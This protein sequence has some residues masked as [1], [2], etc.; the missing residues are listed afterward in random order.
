MTEHDRFERLNPDYVNEHAD[1]SSQ[2]SFDRFSDLNPG[3]YSES[4]YAKRRHIIDLPVG[5]AAYWIVG[6]LM[7]L[8]LPLAVYVNII[9][10]MQA[11]KMLTDLVWT[12]PEDIS[13]LAGTT[14]LCKTDLYADSKSFTAS[15]GV[16]FELLQ[17]QAYRNGNRTKY[18][19]WEYIA[20]AP[21]TLTLSSADKKVKVSVKPDDLDWFF[22]E[23]Y[24]SGTGDNMDAT[25]YPKE[26]KKLIAAHPHNTYKLSGLPAM[27]KITVIGLVER[28]GNSLFIK[29]FAFKHLSHGVIASSATHEQL[30]IIL[31]DDTTVRDIR[32]QH[33]QN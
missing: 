13:K 8:L 17:K 10:P 1:H 19:F 20:N 11:N 26:W 25:T 24:Y 21:D 30:N 4:N 7:V 32:Q 12:K 27:H 31:R 14:K 2:P 29:P 33:F 15:N 5:N 28:E 22:F 23:T 6:A 3:H 18:L 9:L 16:A